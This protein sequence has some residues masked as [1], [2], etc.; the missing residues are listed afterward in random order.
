MVTAILLDREARSASSSSTPRTACCVAL[1]K[2]LHVLRAMEYNR[3]RPGE[4]VHQPQD[5]FGE[6]VF[7][8]QRLQLLFQYVPPGPVMEAGL[9]SPEPDCDG[10]I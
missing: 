6:M 1:L 2:A 7:E 3:R 8:S 10:P 5:K 4:G 9:V